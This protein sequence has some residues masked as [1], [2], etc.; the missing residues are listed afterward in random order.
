MRHKKSIL[1]IL[2]LIVIGVAGYSI[3]KLNARYGIFYPGRYKCWQEQGQWKIG[4]GYYAGG[5]YKNHRAFTCVHNYADGG[6]PCGNS[7]ECLGGKCIIYKTSDAPKCIYNNKTLMCSEVTVEKFKEN[8]ESAKNAGN[9][10][11][12]F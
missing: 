8:P 3:L 12:E 4:E 6:K 1:I 2:I 7:N 10:C 5:L 9:A 11:Y